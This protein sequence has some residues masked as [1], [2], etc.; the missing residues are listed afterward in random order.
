MTFEEILSALLEAKL[1]PLRAD[2]RA[3]AQAIESMQRTLP[4]VLVPVREAAQ[5]LGVSEVTVRRQIRD[6]LLSVR[7]IGRSVRVDMTALR[8][9]TDEEVEREAYRVRTEIPRLPA[10][11]QPGLQCPG[12]AGQGDI[13]GRQEALPVR[14]SRI[15]PGPTKAAGQQRHSASKSCR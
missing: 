9:L 10:S 14:S 3:L 6:H 8:P 2:L 4:P 1:A 5:M 12:V 7:R 11:G 15:G 13:R